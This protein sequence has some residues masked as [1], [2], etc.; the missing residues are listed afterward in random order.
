MDRAGSEDLDDGAGDDVDLMRV[1]K[2]PA[3]HTITVRASPVS[4]S[5]GYGDEDQKCLR[6]MWRNH[7]VDPESLSCED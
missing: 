4:R 3:V 6:G 1:H 2:P 5:N 7:R